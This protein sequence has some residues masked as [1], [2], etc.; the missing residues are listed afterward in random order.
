MTRS[1]PLDETQSV[2][3]ER[4]P[5]AVASTRKSLAFLESSF[6]V[7]NVPSGPVRISTSSSNRNSLG[8]GGRPSVSTLRNC[9]F[10]TAPATGVP[11]GPSTRPAAARVSPG[12]IVTITGSV[13]PA[14][15]FTGSA[16]LRSWRWAS[17]V[18]SPPGADPDD[19]ELARAIGRL[20][21]HTR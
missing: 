16:V 3:L 19:R 17:I 9:T 10:T 21:D 7:R 5:S 8:V 1:P 14:M 13:P 2:C 12:T 4:K 18:T 20:H 6:G 11:P 15:A